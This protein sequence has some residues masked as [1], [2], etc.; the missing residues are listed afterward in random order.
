M[1]SATYRG[2]SNGLMGYSRTEGVYRD[3]GGGL[4]TV[5]CSNGHDIAGGTMQA[6]VDDSSSVTQYYGNLTLFGLY[7]VVA[8]LLTPE[9]NWN[10]DH[11]AVGSDFSA[12]YYTSFKDNLIAHTL[13]GQNGA[14]ARINPRKGS[15]LRLTTADLSGC[16]GCPRGAPA[17]NGWWI[18]KS[19]KNWMDAVNNAA[20]RTI[21]MFDYPENIKVDQ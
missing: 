20:G 7:R 21:I 9:D 14:G 1:A 18:I 6:I 19:L 10:A 17:R 2:V 12:A 8:G 11:Y 3:A 13:I 15:I 5:L 4:V 16:T